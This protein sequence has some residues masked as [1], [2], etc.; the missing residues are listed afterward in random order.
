MK[1]ILFFLA[2]A[3]LT[4]DVPAQI[5]P[6]WLMNP[7]ISPDGQTIAFG[8]KGRLYTVNASGG[9]ATPLTVGGAYDQ[10]PVWSHDGKSIAFA[11][12]RYGNF[13][14]FV[15]PVKGGT[16]R[17]LTYYSGNDFPTD[18][19]PDNKKVLFLSARNAP[20]KSVR[21]S[22]RLFLNLY[23]VSAN[24]GRPV[25]VSAAG[26]ERAHYNSS[27]SQIIFED[28]KGY[29]D[30]W[31][32]HATSAVTR[33]VWLFDVSSQ[34]YKQIST[35]NGEDRE[36]VFSNDGKSVYYL[37]EQK[38]TQNIFKTSLASNTSNQ[39]L[40][41]F[42]TNPVRNL[43]RSAN[44]ILCFTWNGEIYTMHPNSQPAKVSIQIA[45]AGDDDIQKTIPVSGNI[46]EFAV[47]PNGK[48]IAFVNRGEIFVTAVE[49]GETKRVTNTPQQE[50][51]VQWA[52]DGR[53]LIYAT[54]RGNS[55][56]IYKSSIVR[57]E[58]PYFYASTILKEESVIASEKE[59]FQ[60]KYSPDGK[61][62]GYIEERNILKV[63][64]VDTKKTVTILPEGNNYSYADGDW[65]FSWSPD[66]KWLIFDNSDGY[67]FTSNIAMR[68]AD[69]SSQISFPVNSGFGEGNGKWALDGKALLWQ[70]SK[71]GRKSLAFQGSSEDDIY[72]VF[73]DKEAYDQFKLSKED[74]AL[75]QE[76][77]KA[78]DSAK[79]KEI[80]PGEKKVAE[81]SVKELK[82]DLTDLENR[83]VRLTINSSTI[84]DYA[85]AK[86]SNKLYYLAAFEKGFD[87]WE[88]NPRTHNTRILAK[89]GSTGGNLSLSKDGST[90]I[91]SSNGGLIQ[92]NTKNGKVTPVPIKSNMLLDEAAER[93]Y[94]FEH[95]W[96]QVKKKIYD[97][98]LGGASWDAYKNIYQRF[99][100]HINNNYDFQVLLSEFLGELDVSHSGGRYR[101][102]NKDG[103]Q[104]A[105]LGLL[106]DETYK[107]KGLK[108]TEVIAGGPID[109]AKSKV[110]PGD[111]LEA[112]DGQPITDDTDWNALLN[113]KEGKNTLLSFSGSAGNWE[114]VIRP[115]SPGAE[116][117][118]MYNRWTKIMA[119]MVDRLSGGKIGYVHVKSMNDASFRDTYD[120]VMGKERDKKALI[121]DTRF[122][123]GGWL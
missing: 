86:D 75:L 34:T 64:D 61:K 57:K 9:T 105:T 14:V 46:S 104:T 121:V 58:E 99:L 13:D 101:P 52:P 3:I 80:K 85:L 40:T 36:P 5:T 24:G 113:H 45:N 15:I 90:L 102:N 78:K 114:E 91:L 39:Q 100:P 17:R 89:L 56:D 83:Q 29:E 94:I 54:E 49:N 118:L 103:D 68:K 44:D 48:E 110:K 60:P 116:V 81:D 18:F 16:A 111:I 93:A 108:I 7:S 117:T 63:Y 51:M 55:W 73:F 43:S 30:A 23:E 21:Y 76:K 79:S 8:Y 107:G 22:I 31:R 32:K 72:A 120:R 70:S 20:A 37:S 88:T 10:M 47:S 84:S 25:L 67:G 26:M 1:R 69:G 4:Y 97:P 6:L 96:R 38:G 65:S 109:L 112:I 28:V 71:L 82:L 12:D 50:R 33:D 59:E 115:G 41:T 77:E 42:K 2:L 106:Y 62:I 27:G 119:D 95:A 122:N 53:S 123:G 87:L 11:S 19:S 35:F 92:V 98:K 66:S 74:F